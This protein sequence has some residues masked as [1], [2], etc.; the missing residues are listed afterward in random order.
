MT[1]TIF[2]A[3]GQKAADESSPTE[4]ALAE[5]QLYGYRPFQDEPDPR[6]PPEARTVAVSISD[7][8]D[9]LVVALGDTRMEPDLQDLLWSTVNLFHRA[10]HRIE[11]ELDDNEQAQRR[12]Q[13]EQDGSEI[14]AVE[15][16][17]LTAEGQTLVER[18]N[19]MEFFRDQAVDQFERH[20]RSA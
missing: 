3:V 9:A 13:K 7:I 5:L 17:R 18:R 11:R 12:S 2:S 16:E 19:C 8:F 6:P 4:H 1:K 14:R 20:T 15:L 10:T